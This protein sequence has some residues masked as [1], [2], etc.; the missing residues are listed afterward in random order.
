MQPR[1]ETARIGPGL[2][3]HAEGGLARR[4]RRQWVPTWRALS[5]QREPAD[6]RLAERGRRRRLPHPAAPPLERKG[7]ASLSQATCCQSTLPEDSAEVRQE[8]ANRTRM[9]G[10]RCKKGKSS[11]ETNEHTGTSEP[12]QTDKTTRT[13][14]SHSVCVRTGRTTRLSSSHRG[15]CCGVT[16]FG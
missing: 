14:T 7:D 3:D 2:S 8:R 15:S 13:L 12:A 10:K 5:R 4:R 16:E 11:K 9:E 1:V 6:T